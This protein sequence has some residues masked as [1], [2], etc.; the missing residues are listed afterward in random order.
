M[1]KMI[2]QY[3]NEAFG[4]NKEDVRSVDSACDDLNVENKRSLDFASD[5]FDKR[6]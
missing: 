5:A 2:A 3:S 1:K 4:L 6:I